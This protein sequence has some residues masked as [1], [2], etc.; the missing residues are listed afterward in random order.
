MKRRILILAATSVLLVFGWMSG[1]FDRGGQESERVPAIHPRAPEP[2]P[3]PERAETGLESMLYVPVEIP[4]SEVA[5]LVNKVVPDSL[6]HVR[7]MKIQGGIFGI[8][9]D[10]DLVRDGAIETHTAFGSVFSRLPLAARGRVRIPPGVW[11]PFESTFIVSATTDLTLDEQ[12]RTHAST[13]ATMIWGE[14]P[15]ITVA[16]IKISLKGAF[17]DALNAEL[18][19]LVPEIDRIIE[20][21]LNL[22]QEVEKVWEDL[23]EPI[24]IRDEP[25]MW[26]SIV[27]EKTF[28]TPP[29]SRGDT[30]VVELWIG[31]TVETIVGDRPE[32]RLAGDLPPLY[33]LPDSLR[34]DS[35]YGFTIHL[36]V[37]I[38]YE[39]ARS[40]VSKTL[41]GRQ[42]EIQEHVDVE[43]RDIVLYGSGQSLIAQVDFSAGLSETSVGTN[44]RIYFTGSPT[45]DPDEQVIWVD[46]FDYDIESRDALTQAAAWVLKERFLEETRA[47]LRFP[48][49]AQILLAREQL[50]EALKYRPIGKHI[51]LSGTLDDLTPG[52]IYLVDDGIT[53]DIFATGRL[54]VRIR[55]LDAAV[56]KM[57]KLV[58]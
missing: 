51:V 42:I 52:E 15:S 6:Y 39:D 30:V 54:E 40:I 13:H 18:E 24:P 41:E 9:L 21:E 12:W 27:P 50:A 58:E 20:H 5:A 29:E 2:L 22:R 45:Y 46:S 43:L 55:D 35:T 28:Y 4:V 44:G 49:G 57:P 19:Q 36:P 34:A 7:D 38:T 23:T 1:C 17:E 37:S 33:R 3:P 25:P 11:R 32:L 48:I 31:A 26:L 47:Q 56:K 14:A 8:K 10:L 16:G 53:V